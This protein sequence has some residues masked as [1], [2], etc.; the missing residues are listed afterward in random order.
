VQRQ[1]DDVVPIPGTKR[2]RYLEENVAAVD[3][4]LPTDDVEAI[5]A[6]V[7]A[8]AVAGARYHESQMGLL[9]G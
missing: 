8:D 1:G 6:A 5:E 4:E 2:R 7:L 9:N 3:I